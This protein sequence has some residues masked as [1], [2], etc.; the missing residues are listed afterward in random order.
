MLEKRPIN[1]GDMPP[2][3]L[4]NAITLTKTAQEQEVKLNSQGDASWKL[5]NC[6]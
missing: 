3:A 4:A 6:G 1:G 2:F 5:V